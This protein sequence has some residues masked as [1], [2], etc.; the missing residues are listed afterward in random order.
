[1]A[2]KGDA[3]RILKL[4]SVEGMYVAERNIILKEDLE[5]ARS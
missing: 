2:K 1:M 3:T 4:K 5:I